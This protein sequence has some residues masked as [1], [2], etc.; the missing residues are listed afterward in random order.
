MK[1]SG[2]SGTGSGK[3]GNM[4]FATVNGQ[5][6]VRQYQPN[7][8]NPN[9]VSQSNSRA[10]LKLLSQLSAALGDVIAIPR[11]GM[12]SSRNR[13]I[14]RNYGLAFANNGEAQLSYENI[15]LTIGNGGLA[16][17]TASRDANNR[18]TIALQDD[19]SP[20]IS[21]VV[22]IV[23]KKTDEGELALIKDIVTE[24]PGENRRFEVETSGVAGELVFFAYAM[25]DANAQATAKFS[26]MQVSSG[27]DIAKLVINR[28]ITNAEYG[29]T[30]TRGATMD[31]SGNLIEPIPAGKVRVYVTKVGQ[32]EVSG[33]GLV[34]EGSQV[35]VNAVPATNYT[36]DGWYLQA[37]GGQTL[38]SSN[39]QYTFTANETVDLVAQFNYHSGGG[40]DS[41]S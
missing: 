13:F 20:A 5:Q 24:I 37:D 19:A 38:V 39:Q 27:V 6:V 30:G 41:G 16:A 23:Y 36:F 1:L 2:I 7:V 28:T 26:N 40:F 25:K 8:T 22:Y 31:A 11:S 10:K 21:R 4:V 17:I 33:G 34:D 15:Q 3:L 35:T 29:F 18:L 32:G 12:Q 9:T 14:K